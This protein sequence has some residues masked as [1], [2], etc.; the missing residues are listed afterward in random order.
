MEELQ[1][2]N[3]TYGNVRDEKE[4][5]E[6]WKLYEAVCN[7]PK[8]AYHG[9]LVEK[10]SAVFLYHLAAMRRQLLE[11]FSFQARSGFWSLA[12]ERGR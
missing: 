9:L 12:Q 7:Y 3:I 8:E 1:S 2:R 11:W 6:L 10:K 5:S 4:T